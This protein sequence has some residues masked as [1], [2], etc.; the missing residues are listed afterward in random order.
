ML[1][2]TLSASDSAAAFH[3]KATVLLLTSRTSLNHAAG[4]MRHLFFALVSLVPL[5]AFAD[6]GMWTFDNFPK[7]ALKKKHNVDVDDKWL[8]QARLSSVRL[9][10]GCSASFVSPDG[11]VM[12]NHHCAHGCIEQVSSKQND[13]IKNGFLAATPADEKKCPTMEVNQLVE[14]VDMTDRINNATKG[15]T[16][17]D[18]AT[19]MKAEKA[20]IEKACATS[21]A[22]RCDV[23]TLYQ[24]GKYHLYKYKRHQDVRLVFAPEL[25]IAFFGGDPDNFNFPRYDLDMSFVRVYENGAPIK[26]EHYFK[27]SDGALKE[28][29]VTFVAGHPGRTSRLNTMSQLEFARN[30]SLPDTLIRM[31]ELRG[32]LTEFQRRGEEQKRVSTHDL[33]GIENGFKA[34]KGRLRALQ[35]KTFFDSKVAAEKA[36]VAGLKGAQQKEVTAAIAAIDA[37]LARLNTIRAE[38]NY[39]ESR[40]GFGGDLFDHAR[41]LVRAGDERVKT[42][43]TRLREYTE[44]A[45]PQ[46]LQAVQ[47]NAPIS[48][49]LEIAKLSFSLTKLREVLGTD[50]PVVKRVLGEKSPDELAASLVKGTKLKDPAVRKQLWD[51]GKAAIDA[52]TDPMIVLAKSVD[53]EARALRKVYEDDMDAVIKKNSEIIAKARFALYGT[54]TYPDATFTLRLNYG[55]V[56]GWTEGSK[57]IA[58]FTTFEGAFNRHTGRDPFALPK[59]W[60]DSKPT[61]AMQTPFNVVTTNDIIGGNSGSPMFNKNREIVGLIFDGNIHSLGGEYGFDER[62]NRTVAVHSEAIIAALAS[63]YKAERLVHELRPKVKTGMN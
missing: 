39:L 19:A 37:A 51:G 54:S 11:L 49:E 8:E 1:P 46:L 60:L 16:G 38:L 17:Q 63:I 34:L 48:D 61:L 9:A 50:H 58:P 23:V 10:G 12:T 5:T 21:D 6:E 41:L 40:A 55:V 62:L 35:D 43:E 29:D 15:K 32:L 47:S 24:G 52:S 33:F 14:I 28:G 18:Y 4:M 3:T 36:F 42:N 13:Y 44:G 30:Q 31:A 22:L 25:A 57:E 56:K 26:S 2:G 59:R 7:A 45:L 20:I 53:P 27:W